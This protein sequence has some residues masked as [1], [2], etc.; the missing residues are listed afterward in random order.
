VQTGKL[1][2]VGYRFLMLPVIACVFLV[3]W[4]MYWFGDLKKQ[5]VKPKG[6]VL[7]F[8]LPD[9]ETVEVKA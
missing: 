5:A 7:R 9:G 8:Q 2:Q 1:K 4:V 3:G 6:E